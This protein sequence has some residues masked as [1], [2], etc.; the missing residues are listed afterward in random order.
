MPP[1]RRT[2]HDEPPRSLVETTVAFAAAILLVFYLLSWSPRFLLLVIFVLYAVEAARFV[3]AK[4]WSFHATSSFA[5]LSV[6]WPLGFGSVIAF[7]QLSPATLAHHLPWITVYINAAVLG[8]IA[9]MGF[10]P[11]GPGAVR[12]YTHRAACLCLVVWLVREMHAVH[13][14]TVSFTEHGYF[15]FNAS[16]LSWVFAHAAYRAVMMTLPPFDTMRYLVLEPA[17][18]GLMAMFA[19]MNNA[20]ASLWF[21]Q[22]DTLVAATVCMTS[23]IL[24]WGRPSAASPDH[25]MRLPESS[26]LGLTC[27]AVHLVV[28]VVSVYHILTI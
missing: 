2:S 3:S 20:P 6:I 5:K 12:G 15:L 8:N 24:S 13:W 4:D 18:L 21:G 19:A 16:P 9:M 26:S 22:S 7:G 10:I 17:S 28:I 11:P 25:T 1:R 27:V 14:R 23:A